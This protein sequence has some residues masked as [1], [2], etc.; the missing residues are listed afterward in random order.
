LASDLI[1]IL[2][3][4]DRLYVDL[5]ACILAEP[6]RAR[7]FYDEPTARRYG[8]KPIVPS[9]KQRNVEID[10]GRRI[11]WDGKSWEVVNPGETMV[12]LSDEAQQVVTFP[13]IG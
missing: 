6:E 12:W 5:T 3:M 2:L 7:V 9:R 1:Y 10:A 4:T 11:V 13:K 8:E